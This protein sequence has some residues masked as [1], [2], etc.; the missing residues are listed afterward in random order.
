M[1]L[2]FVLEIFQGMLAHDHFH[3]PIHT[4]HQQP[5][6]FVTA[7]QEA[8]PLERRIIAPMKVFESQDERPFAADRFY[9][10]G[11]LPEHQPTSRTLASILELTPFCDAKKC[12]HLYQP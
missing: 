12:R 9:C 8:E 5:R 1:Y 10:V 11:E 7:R 2:E 3:R 4:E 6:R